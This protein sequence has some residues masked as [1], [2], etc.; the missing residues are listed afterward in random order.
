[1]NL[2]AKSTLL[3][4]LSS[5]SL[6]LAE[7]SPRNLNAVT[8]F[9]IQSCLKQFGDSPFGG[10]SINY[11]ILAP[12]INVLNG[13]S[14]LLDDAKTT[15]PQLI[16]VSAAVNVLSNATYKFLNPQGWYCLAPNVS[17]LGVTNIDLNQSAHFVQLNIAVGSEVKIQKVDDQGQPIPEDKGGEE[18]APSEPAPA[19]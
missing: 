2:L 4:A 9:V 7:E 5:S 3:L 18:P 6:A 19:L 14:I 16:I 10:E 11:K 15:E 13:T 1:M 12:T 17:V 8:N